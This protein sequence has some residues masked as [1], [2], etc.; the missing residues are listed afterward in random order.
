LAEQQQYLFY[1]KYLPSTKLAAA[2]SWCSYKDFFESRLNINILDLLPPTK[3]SSSKWQSH[4]IVL[5]LL[6]KAYIVDL[7]DHNIPGSLRSRE[8]VEVRHWE[9]GWFVHRIAW[10][11]CQKTEILTA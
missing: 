11:D 6:A 7:R 4:S 1:Y 9:R 2:L 8:W 5:P 3:Q 10:I